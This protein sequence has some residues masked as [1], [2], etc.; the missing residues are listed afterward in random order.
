MYKDNLESNRLTTRF[1]ENSDILIWEK[2]F[3]DSE[4]VLFFPTFG[5]K[6]NLERSEFW[7][8]K[9][10]A[11]YQENRFGLQALIEKETGEFIGQ[12]GLLEQNVDGEIKIEVGYHV[13]KKHWGKGFAP[14]AAKLFIDFA[15]N[16]NI[17]DSIISI[18]DQ[19]NIKSQKVA[20][21]NGLKVIK[22]SIWFDSPVFIY[23]IKK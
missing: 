5:L 8:E 3:E 19:K 16:N 9:Q 18:I 17:S 14:E 15:F 20:D 2:F 6:S 23:E 21:K 11:R 7:I 13:F 4:A 22:E 12:C 10:L 1:L